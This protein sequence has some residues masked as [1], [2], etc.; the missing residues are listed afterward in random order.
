ML[1]LETYNV[2]LV[3]DEPLLLHSLE[4]Y[5][6][7]ANLGFSV[8][9]TATNGRE[10]INYLEF[11]NI[12]LIIPDI[13]MPAMTGLELLR[14]VHHHFPNIS[15][16]VLSGYADFSYAQEALQNDAL[17]YVLKPVTQE[18]VIDMLLKAK[19]KLDTRYQLLEEHNL[20]GQTVEQSF[21]YVRDYL[22]EHFSEPIELN[23]LAAQLGY[24]PAYLTKIFSKYE[25]CTP[26]KYLTLLRITQAKQLLTNTAL[27]IKEIGERV[28]YS[29]QFYFSRTFHKQVGK[30]PS[31]YREQFSKGSA[32]P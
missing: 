30:T 19:V 21:Q 10:A 3:E 6:D 7:N 26:I 18:L 23:T 28:G 22:K 1:T 20:S 27:T 17:N 5:I 16:I 11:Q 31:E 14:Y 13:I 32:E 9:K 2:L 8:V 25:N 29:N 24:S 4:R 12:H 15:V